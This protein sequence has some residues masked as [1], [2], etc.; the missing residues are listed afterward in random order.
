MN[1]YIQPTIS[2]IEKIDV[3]PLRKTICSNGMP[4]YVMSTGDE[5]VMRVDVIISAGSWEQS[6]KMQSMITNLLL[7]EGTSSHTSAQIA[8]M[9]DFYGA[10]IQTTA[11]HHHSYLT[12]YT[13]NKYSEPMLDLMR[14]IIL[15]PTFPESELRTTMARRKQNY[16]TEREKVQ[17]MASRGFL[18]ALYGKEHPYGRSVELSDFDGLTTDD[19]K[20]FHRKYYCSGNCQVLISGKINDKTVRLIERYFGA[21]Q[22][23]GT[24]C[25]ESKEHQMQPSVTRS[26][27]IP[28]A[29]A[30]QSAVR[31]GIPVIR[32][33]HPDFQKLKVV[34]TI[35]GGYFGSR[36]MSNIREDKGYTYGIGSGITVYRKAA[37]L[38]VSTQT[39]C[40]YTRP[41]IAEV[42][43]EITRL[44]QEL[45]SEEELTMVKNYMIG[46]FCRS[47]ESP[48]SIAEAYL[49]LIIDDMDATYLISQPESVKNITAEEV[50]ETALRYLSS[51]LFYEIVAGKQE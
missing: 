18:S 25:F 20:M 11:T 7:K 35:L 39:A 32:R 38:C 50:R 34:N 10:S 40:Q 49:S 17:Y 44:Q 31:I 41:L 42:Y 15:S 13:L 23:G 45:V 37:Y 5:E 51:D 8:E 36:L 26:L 9:I 2:P 47:L 14:E 24:D 22:W 33:N 28:K 4:L 30:L 43:R 1:R 21:E 12:L 29:N 19:L 27:F 46:E 16:L 3:P 48:F 6:K